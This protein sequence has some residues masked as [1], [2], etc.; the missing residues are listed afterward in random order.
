MEK[1]IEFKTVLEE[2]LEID[3][4][5]KRDFTSEEKDEMLINSR[6]FMKAFQILEA[7]NNIE[8]LS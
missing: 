6:L 4:W 3:D 1:F 5:V 2:T 8:T 7:E